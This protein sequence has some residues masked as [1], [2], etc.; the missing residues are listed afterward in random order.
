MKKILFAAM[1]ALVSTAAAAQQSTATAHI[2]QIV[3]GWGYD[4][5]SVNLGSAIN[6]PAGCAATDMA[7]VST[8]SP[9]YKTYYAAALTAFSSDLPVTLVISTTACE[10]VRPRI[11]GIQLNH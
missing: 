1:L 5:F 4:S 10:G 6:N 2:T 9:G 11:I 3:T 8:D 7:A